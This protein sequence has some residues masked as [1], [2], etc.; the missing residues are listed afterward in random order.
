MKVGSDAAA[1]DLSDALDSQESYG[2][3]P[4]IQTIARDHIK[5]VHRVSL[6]VLIF[7]PLLFRRNVDSGCLFSNAETDLISLHG[8]LFAA[9]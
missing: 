1:I 6:S 4:A 9:M 2:S 7:T 5:I 8:H 3:D